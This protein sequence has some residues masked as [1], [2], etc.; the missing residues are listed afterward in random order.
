LSL[1][2]E[3]KVKLSPQV[4]WDGKQLE[5]SK[6]EGHKWGQPSSRLRRVSILAKRNWK[7]LSH[8]RNIE[9]EGK[10]K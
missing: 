1:P 7:L 3:K 10:K 9:E 5:V 6:R 4:V 8:K 2:G